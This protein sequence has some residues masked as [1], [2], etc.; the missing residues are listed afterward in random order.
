MARTVVDTPRTVGELIDLLSKF[1]RKT[2][3]TT[4]IVEQYDN[5]SRYATSS[6]KIAI[7]QYGTD[8]I[9]LTFANGTTLDPA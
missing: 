6:D 2:E 7:D 1:D 3:L 4:Y 8:A 5:G 9:D